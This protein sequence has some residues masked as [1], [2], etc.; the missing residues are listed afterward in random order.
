VAPDHGADALEA[1]LRDLERIR[2]RSLVTPDLEVARTLRAPDYQLITPGGATLSREAYLGAIASGELDYQ[3]VEPA[4]EIAVLRLGDRG[5]ALRYQARIE[6][7]FD[8]DRQEEGRYWHTDLYRLLESGWQVTWSQT[9]Q[10][11]A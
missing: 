3:V 5:A 9:T 8:G 6:V 4:S 10:I 7:R 11:N 1:T 2:L